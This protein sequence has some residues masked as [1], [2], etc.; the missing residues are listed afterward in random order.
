[1]VHTTTGRAERVETAS[2]PNQLY[3]L[4]FR[5]LDPLLNLRFYAHRVD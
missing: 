4:S 3:E 1:M 2:S 5:S